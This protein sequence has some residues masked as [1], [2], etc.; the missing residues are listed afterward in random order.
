MK[1]LCLAS[2]VIRVFSQPQSICQLW[3]SWQYNTTT[4]LTSSVQ[5]KEN[6]DHDKWTL[7]HDPRI[8]ET[9]L[10][11]LCCCFDIVKPNNIEW[12]SHS[13]NRI[14]YPK[15]CRRECTGTS[16][17]QMC[18][19]PSSECMRQFVTR[20]IQIVLLLLACIALH[21]H[22]ISSNN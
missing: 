14:C 18:T 6:C 11:R 4:S 20:S 21:H 2:N 13:L 7:I 15:W 17:F 1:H 8:G 5:H 10:G 3:L 19:F 12:L 22:N 9:I 16:N